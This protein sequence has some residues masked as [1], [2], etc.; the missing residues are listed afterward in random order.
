MRDGPKVASADAPMER[1]VR[2]AGVLAW[3]IGTGVGFGLTH[4]P[5]MAWL[6]ATLRVPFALAFGLACGAWVRWASMAFAHSAAEAVA[7]FAFPSGRSTPYEASFSAHDARA[8]A[9]DVPGAIAAYEGTLR[10]QPHNPVALRQAAELHARHGDVV[11]AVE[12][13]VTLRRV[14]GTAEYEMYASQRLADLHLG[15]LDD[16]GRALVE[17][18][19]IVERFPGTAQ[20]S[21]ARL[22]IQRLKEARAAREHGA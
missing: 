14:G 1:K 7:S 10:E 15:P 3:F 18:R 20:A 4:T 17:L 2:L 5:T 6:P 16:E 12:L 13:F 19:R 21:G 8:A 9:G 11:R 22:A